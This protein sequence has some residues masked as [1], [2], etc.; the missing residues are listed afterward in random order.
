MHFQLHLTLNFNLKSF[1]FQVQYRR[2]RHRS[3]APLLFPPS[4]GWTGQAAYTFSMGKGRGGKRRGVFELYKRGEREENSFFGAEE[5]GGR[6][7]PVLACTFNPS[8]KNIVSLSHQPSPPPLLLQLLFLL[9]DL[10]TTT[11]DAALLKVSFFLFAFHWVQVRPRKTCKKT[12]RSNP[13]PRTEWPP[14]RSPSSS[15]VNC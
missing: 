11:N 12:K 6:S 14:L 15:S 7:L 10:R 8:E 3:T 9:H 2:C 13:P 1:D 4:M 5:R